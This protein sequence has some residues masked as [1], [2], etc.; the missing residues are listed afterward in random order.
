MIIS[1]VRRR[2][3]SGGLN[4]PAPPTTG[5][6]AFLGRVR[7][8]NAGR[9]GLV[10]IHGVDDSEAVGEILPQ[11][12]LFRS[13]QVDALV[14]SKRDPAHRNSG[15][16]LNIDLRESQKTPQP[17]KCCHAPNVHLSAREKI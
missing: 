14:F 10:L 5:A 11:R 4:L 1:N 16:G 9:A 7:N 15:G 3:K 2:R 6:L 8:L 13:R 17:A 12:R